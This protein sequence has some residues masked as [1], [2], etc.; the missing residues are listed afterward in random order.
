MSRSILWKMRMR[1]SNWL[2]PCDYGQKITLCEGMEVRFNDMGHLLGS[3][4]IE[5][6][7][8]EDGISKKIVFSGDV[9]NTNQPIIR[10]PQK[11]AEADYVVIESTY[12]D[13]THAMRCRIISENLRRY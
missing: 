9:G 13:R 10:D 12:G 7:I 4:S 6:W 11:V 2:A 5:V 1:P 8:T 3:A